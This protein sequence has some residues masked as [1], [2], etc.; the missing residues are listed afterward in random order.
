MNKL[1]ETPDGSKTRR[2]SERIGRGEGMLMGE[3]EGGG[4]SKKRGNTAIK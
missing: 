2:R 3:G 1:G 4:G